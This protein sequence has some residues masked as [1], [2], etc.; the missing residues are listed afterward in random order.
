MAVEP[1][2]LLQQVFPGMAED[3]LHE[4]AQLARLRTYPAQTLLCREGAEENTFYIIGEGQTVITQRFGNEERFLRNAG[5]GQYFG[6]MALIANTPRNANVRTTVETTVLEIDKAAFVEMIRQNPIIA[7]TMFRT[8]V[9]WLR[10]NDMAAIAALTKQK[11]EIEHAY[12]ELSV[13]ERR[14]SEFLTTLAH[15]LRTPLTT[16]NGYIQLIKNGTMS[17][18]PLTMAIDKVADGV[19]RIVS[20]INDL[21]FVQEMDLIEPAVRPVDLP[22]I[23]E[24]IIDEAE[25]RA[26]E[27]DLTI[28]LTIP[29][30]LPE[31]RADPDGL[32]RALR[33]LVDNAIKFSP[34]GGQIR[35]DVSVSADHLNIAITDPGV[36]IEPEYMPR[37]FARY[38]RREQR[39]DLLFGG[40]G[41]GLPI[42]KHLIESFGGSISVQSEVDHGSTFTVHLPVLLVNQPSAP[43]PDGAEAA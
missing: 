12:D 14:R 10:A 15:E 38:E 42:A 40:I 3:A 2:S 32:S 13:Q 33:A 5:P 22:E 37:L 6:E 29:P 11:Q 35:I 1:V 9:G 25:D 36:G 20:L 43:A 21:L 7:L 34:G 4:M 30:A 8:S 41:L 23:L 17:G 39:G 24:S 26:A 19:E 18:A 27:N 31:V 16:A 28:Q